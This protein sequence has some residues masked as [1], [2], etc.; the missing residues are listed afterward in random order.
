[1]IGF[2]LSRQVVF[3]GAVTGITYGIMAVGV[4]LI[5]R[6]SRII[7]LAIAEMGGL[8]AAVLAFLVINHHVSYWVAFPACVCLGAAVGA[9]IELVVVRRLFDAP[10][11]LL[12]V[13]TIG[14][15]QLL[16]FAQASLAR[17]ECACAP[18]RRRSLAPGPSSVCFVR[19]EH[20]LVLVVVPLLTIALALFLGRTRHGLAIRAAAANPS[21]ARLAG[22]SVRRMSTAVWALAG[23]FSAARDD[24]RGAVHDLDLIGGLHARAG[25]AGASPGRRPDRRHDVDDRRAGRRRRHRDRRERPLLQQPDPARPHRCAPARDRDRRSA[26]HVPPGLCP[27]STACR[28]VVVRPSISFCRPSARAALGRPAPFAAGRP[29]RAAPR[30]CA[31]RRLRPRRRS[32]SCGVACSSTRSPRSRSPCS[33]AGPA[34]SRSVRPRSPG[35]GR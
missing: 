21:A 11:V 20:V 35:W 25:P 7:N 4:V 16:L 5:Y 22:I 1:M 24:P 34:S 6:S 27:S 15:S 29:G 33:P 3:S 14:V 28:V 30:P 8:A 19:S 12:L 23:A 13:A 2:A 18:I 9:I 31:V 10:R 17:S 32:S 26:G